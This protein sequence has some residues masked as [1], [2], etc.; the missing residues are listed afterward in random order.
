LATAARRAPI[1]RFHVIKESLMKSNIRSG[2]R[3]LR[4]AS[5]ALA[6]S[7]ICAAPQPLAAATQTVVIEP[8][9]YADG[10]VLN[11]VSPFVRLSTGAFADYRPT[12]DVTAVT[13]VLGASTG[14]KVF[15]H[16]P[17]VAFW[18][19]QRVLRMDFL[20]PATEISIDYIGSGTG[21]GS[22]AGLL[23]AYLANGT[24]VASDTTALMAGGVHERM[25]VAA[26][27]IDYA[28]AYPPSDTFGDL[29]HLAFTVPEPATWLLLSLGTAGCWCFAI[30]V[31]RKRARPA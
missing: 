2:P 8:D 20:V 4:G 28:F 10:Q 23:Q 14:N 18:N 22:F 15:A 19:N 1:E 27:R 29:D 9:D 17:G 12:F 11:T 5:L 3:W 6:V 26:S 13:D 21:G 7:A 30:N 24:L 25:S 16:G 31:R